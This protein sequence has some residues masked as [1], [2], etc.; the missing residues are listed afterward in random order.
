VRTRIARRLA[1]DEVQ[2]VEFEAEENL[3]GLLEGEDPLALQHIMKMR[4]GN[5]RMLG[6]PAFGGLSAAYAAA[7]VLEKVLLK[8]VESHGKHPVVFLP[9]IG[10]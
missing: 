2:D 4:L 10:V 8:I 5:A 9:A 6:Q 7:E 1:G 3:V